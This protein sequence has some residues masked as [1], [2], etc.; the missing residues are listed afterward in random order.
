MEVLEIARV[1]A[2]CCNE[3]VIHAKNRSNYLVVVWEGTCMERDASGRRSSQEEKVFLGEER[4]VKRGKLAVWY[5]GDWTGPRILQPEKR[6]SGDSSTNTTHDIVA[7]SSEGVK[8]IMVDFASLHR[9]LSIGSVLYQKY[10]T[11]LSRTHSCTIP[12]TVNG[13]MFDVFTSA[14]ENLNIIELLDSNT[15]LRKLTAVQK[16]HLECLVEG[17]WVFAPGQRLWRSGSPVDKAFIVVAGTVSFV[18]KRQHAGSSVGNTM[19]MT[20]LKREQ[21]SNFCVEAT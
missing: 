5:A 15:G 8:A 12:V 13:K 10:H 21:V 20:R 17:P 7:M 1:V 6:L 19:S 14:V 2:Y 3:I 9:I 11:S 4:E 18:P 16:R